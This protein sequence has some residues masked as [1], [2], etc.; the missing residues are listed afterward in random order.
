V[1]FGYPG[2]VRFYTS[3]MN[4]F[5]LRVFNA[6]AMDTQSVDISLG[7]PGEMKDRVMNMLMEVADGD[8]CF[9][10]Q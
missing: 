5:Y 3:G 6:N 2:L 1:H 7:V 4:K 8:F 10:V 9:L